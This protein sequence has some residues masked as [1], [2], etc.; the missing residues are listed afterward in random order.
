M[1]STYQVNLQPMNVLGFKSDSDI[2]PA[3]WIDVRN[4]CKRFNDSTE[5]C[6]ERNMDDLYTVENLEGLC[7]KK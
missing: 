5:I 7:L 3:N 2:E 4:S 6:L 1:D